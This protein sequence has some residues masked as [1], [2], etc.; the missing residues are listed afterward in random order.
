MSDQSEGAPVTGPD[1]VDFPDSDDFTV[2]QD[3][4]Y[5]VDDEPVDA[6]ERPIDDEPDELFPDEERPVVLDDAPD[7]PESLLGDE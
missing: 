2:A 4:E 6:D 1:S 3:G 5:D 7:A